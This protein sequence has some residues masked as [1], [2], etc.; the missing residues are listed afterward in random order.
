MAKG[1]VY[2]LTNPYM[3]GLVKIGKTTNLNR[4]LGELYKTGVPEPFSCPLAVRVEDTSVIEQGLHATFAAQR[5]NPNR[6]FFKVDLESAKAALRLTGGEDV[7]PK[8]GEEVEQVLRNTQRR[9][10]F[11]F[12]FA[13]IQIG[14][15]ITYYN[16]D[17]ITAKVVADTKILFNNEK[18][19]LTRGAMIVLGGPNTM[20]GPSYWKYDGET[21]TA[22]RLRLEKEFEA[23]VEA[24]AEAF[25]SS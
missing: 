7:T 15:I 17:N 12:S 14:E 6:E 11:R 18:M 3:P 24:L 21:L 2:I 20:P 10:N 4:R 22:R 1:V 9:P 13:G 25:S 16:N 5:I 23:A 8:E 19:S